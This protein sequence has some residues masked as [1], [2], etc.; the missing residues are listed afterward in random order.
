MG[1]R[2]DGLDD[3]VTLIEAMLAVAQSDGEFAE[4]EQTRIRRLI[5][6]LRLSGP[7]ATHVESLLASN[8]TPPMPES[9]E[10]PDYDTRRYIFQHALIMAFEDGQIDKG[11]EKQLGALADLFELTEADETTAWAR[12]REMATP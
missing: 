2:K 3:R 4:I 7:A 1:K 5:E 11:E 6:F 12:A 9:A 8:A 10:L